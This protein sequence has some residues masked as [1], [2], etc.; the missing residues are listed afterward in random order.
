[1]DKGDKKVTHLHRL[2]SLFFFFFSDIADADADCGS[3]SYP[4]HQV[5]L[6]WKIQSRM[7]AQGQNKF[8]SSAIP[9]T[10]S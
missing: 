2:S 3:A 6:L 10:V 8:M 7:A 4:W 5:Y 9:T 1:M